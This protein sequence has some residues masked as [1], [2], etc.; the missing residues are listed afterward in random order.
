MVWLS[1][2]IT[3]EDSQAKYDKKDLMWYKSVTNTSVKYFLNNLMWI[4]CIFTQYYKYIV[5]W[6]VMS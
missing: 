2:K 5:L 6:L 1:Q 4:I 3:Y